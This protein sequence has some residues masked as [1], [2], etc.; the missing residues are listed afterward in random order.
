MMDD[1]GTR[2]PCGKNPHVGTRM[3]KS[4]PP[5]QLLGM[6]TKVLP[7]HG[8]ANG[9]SSPYEKFSIVVSTSRPIKGPKKLSAITF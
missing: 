8:G 4:P 5:F 2:T 9:E 1:T 7:P 6:G 3:G